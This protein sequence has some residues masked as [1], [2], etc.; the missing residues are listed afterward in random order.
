MGQLRSGRL[1]HPVIPIGAGGDVSLGV[2]LDEGVRRLA[3]VVT[4]VEVQR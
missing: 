2:V 4:D 1:L 3:G